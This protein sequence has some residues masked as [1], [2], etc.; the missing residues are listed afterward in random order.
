MIFAKRADLAIL[1]LPIEAKNQQPTEIDCQSAILQHRHVVLSVGVAI[2]DNAAPE[3]VKRKN[4]ALLIFV[5]ACGGYLEICMAA[6]DRV[7]GP[8]VRFAELGRTAS[9]HI[10]LRLPQRLRSR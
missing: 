8:M 6:D 4:A 9:Y 1:A 10:K 5:R 2:T 7:C 3:K